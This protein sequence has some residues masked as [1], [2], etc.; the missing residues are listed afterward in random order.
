MTQTD[1]DRNSRNNHPTHLMEITMMNKEMNAMN[2]EMTAVANLIPHCPVIL[3]LDTS[4]SMW[5][6][7]LTDMM[8]A[9]KTFYKT[10]DD[11]SFMNAKVD[12][13][14][15]SMG[16]NLRML[17]E[18]TPIEESYLPTSSIRPKGDTPI[19]AALELAMKALCAQ[20]KYYQA[21]D[22]SHVTPQLIMLSDG[23]STDDFQPAAEAIRTAVAR[24]QLF[25]RAI[26]TGSD[27]DLAALASIVG[28]DNI[29]SHGF[30]GM[31]SA[32]AQV[33]QAVSQTYEEEA[34]EV[35][36]VQETPSIPRSS[37][38]KSRHSS[39]TSSR[40]ISSLPQSGTV[41]LLDGRNIM[42]WHDE[43]GGVTLKYLLAITD[44]LERNQLP[45]QVLFDATTPHI[46]KKKSPEEAARYE[47]LLKTDR[48][49][50]RQVP[51]GTSADDFLLMVASQNKDA[52][53]MTQDLFRDHHDEHPWLK[54]ENRL[55]RGMVLNDS[56]IFPAISLNISVEAPENNEM[57]LL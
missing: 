34:Q 25:C 56:I 30:G 55:I 24:G 41:Y 17:E 43:Q 57:F 14:A 23:K 40:P 5:G 26:P 46:L 42:H 50:F 37:T 22:I 15:V 6:Q 7:G 48:A 19:G 21:A 9:L 1:A 33:G 3:V 32:F 13:A 38:P 49:H 51:A 18:F 44:Y 8:T 53:I 16:D 12:I 39:S 20:L 28:A 54:N 45:Y 11:N 29:V 36:T 2:T 31:R 4:H 10:L 52:L 47:E 35:I 27:T